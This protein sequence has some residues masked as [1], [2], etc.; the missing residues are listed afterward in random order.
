MTRKPGRDPSVQ[1]SRSRY[2]AS[3]PHPILKYW[4]A[5]NT[6]SPG[7]SR[8][9]AGASL[10]TASPTV[11]ACRPAYAAATCHWAARGRH[12]GARLILCNIAHARQSST[13]L[14]CLWAGSTVADRHP[15]QRV[16]PFARC[17]SLIA[18]ERARLCDAHRALLLPM[19]PD[20]RLHCVFGMRLSW[21]MMR[22]LIV[23]SG[24][25]VLGPSALPLFQPRRNDRLR[26]GP[27]HMPQIN[28]GPVSLSH[29]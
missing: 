18:C 22:R 21:A 28:C 11:P 1:R 3:Y 9:R 10:L 12:M 6:T 19:F 8:G 23:M 24:V 25:V 17:L 13:G 27:Q 5:L 4:C 2:G 20:M 7:Q 14:C 15:N 26:P 29:S 16:G